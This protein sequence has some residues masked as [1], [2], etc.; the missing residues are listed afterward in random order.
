[1]TSRGA[2][3]QGFGLAWRARS[4]AWVLFLANLG[5]AAL[6]GWPIYHGILR[7]TGHSQMSQTLTTGFSVDWL[8]DFSFNS[9]GSLERYGQV[10]TLSGLL[11]ILMDSI[12][13]GG[14]LGC[15]R[16]PNPYRSLADFFGDCGH[17]AWRLLR[18]LMIGLIGYWIVFRV[19]NQG[20]GNLTDNWTRYWLDDRL[21][22]WVKLVPG[23][24]VLL[25]LGFVNLVMDY[26]RVRLVIQDG[27]SAAE[28]FLAAL[29]FSLSR[30]RE[31]VFV[32]V[33]PSLC[34]VALLGVYLLVTPWSRINSPWSATGWREPLT[35]A[36]LFVGQQVIMFGRYWFRVATWASEWSYY[37]GSR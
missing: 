35:L 7:F 18:L 15:F 5:V 21:V 3:K 16:D 26:A 34:G 31:A 33:I 12:L 1:M 36:L 27:A 9:L 20:L 30:L 6:A 2:I 4:A 17:Y 13:A 29:G 28:A 14:V 10:I 24:L 32:Y 11:S 25:G 23:L 37:S 8:T 22:F 19:L